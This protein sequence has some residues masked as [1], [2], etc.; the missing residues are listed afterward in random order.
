MFTNMQS[1]H[2][3][4]EDLVLLDRLSRFDGFVTMFIPANYLPTI[5]VSST[6]SSID[7]FIIIIIK[8]EKD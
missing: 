8:R 2:P 1:N 5:I 3:L 7:S 6:P 4:E